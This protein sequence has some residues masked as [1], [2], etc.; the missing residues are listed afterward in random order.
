MIIRELTCQFFTG[1]KIH[2]TIIQT[3]ERV[4]SKPV[5]NQRQQNALSHSLTLRFYFLLNIHE[6][7]SEAE[8]ACCI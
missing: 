3:T 8:D 4:S 1:K 7:L 2:S 5:C 6:N